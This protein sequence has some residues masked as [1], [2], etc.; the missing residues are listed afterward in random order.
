MKTIILIRFRAILRVLLRQVTS[1]R[2]PFTD[3]PRHHL[4]VPAV[5]QAVQAV[6]AV[7]AVQA[8]EAEAAEAEEVRISDYGNFQKYG[9]YA[10]M[11][12]NTPM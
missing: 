1:I 7:Q 6:R 8:A 9:F 4:T 11:A 12:H 10:P 5:V 3:R 2:Q